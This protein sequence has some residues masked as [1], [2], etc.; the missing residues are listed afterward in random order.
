MPV[1]QGYAAG[2]YVAH[3]Q[4][5]GQRLGPRAWVGV[6]SLCKRNAN[7]SAIETV[8]LAVKAA[9]PDLRLHGFGVKVTAL[10]RQLVRDLL[11]SADS[12][13]WSFAARYEG[14]D[15]NDPAEALA[16]AQ[17]VATMPTQLAL[18]VW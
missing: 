16:Y 2:D 6:G 15:R 13:A 7:P 5:Y 8:L 9:R 4:Q 14:R 3:I 12:M 1:V 18:G 11:Y 17:R 10:S